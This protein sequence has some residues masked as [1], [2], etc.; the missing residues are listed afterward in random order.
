[1][2]DITIYKPVKIFCITFILTWV[3]W[4]IGAYLSY[5]EYSES[6]YVLFML[7]GLIAPFAVALW[8][9]LRSKNAALKRRFIDKLFN[10]RLINPAYIPVILFVM[11][12]VI[13]LSILLSTLMG[14]T[15]DQLQLSPEFS[16][17][18]G[19]VPVLLVLFLAASFEELGWRSYAM[20]SLLSR[21]NFFKASCIFAVLWACW[22]LPLFV[23][24]GYYQ[25]ELL[26]ASPLYAINFL[27]SVIPMAFIIGWICY[28]NN[29]NIFAAIAFHFVINIS[30]E[31]FAITQV[32]KCIET[33]VLLALAAAI[34][35]LNKEMF[36]KQNHS[37]FSNSHETSDSRVINAPVNAVLE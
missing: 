20:D 18:A 24:N 22:H 2:K 11:P 34:V 26:K 35:M 6:I 7:P 17:S 27:V 9:I 29:G 12:L 30:Q 28:K 32:T 14:Q 23:V 37:V 33:V 8:M 3:S 36:F 4:L 25:N 1:M 5:Q 13:I 16:F 21:F 15:I 31:L 19:I 10:F